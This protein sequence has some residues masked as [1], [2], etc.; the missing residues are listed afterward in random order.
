MLLLVTLWSC[1]KEYPEMID[2]SLVTIYA[3]ISFKKN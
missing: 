1:Q 2:F 3:Y